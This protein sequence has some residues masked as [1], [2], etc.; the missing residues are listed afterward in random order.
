MLAAKRLPRRFFLTCGAGCLLASLALGRAAPPQQ[1]PGVAPPPLPVEQIIREFASKEAEFKQARDNYTYTQSVR[2][3]EFDAEGRRGGEFNRVSEIIFT[4]EGKRF[5]R[6]TREPPSTLR[7]VS[8][9]A[10]DLED[11]RNIQPFVLTNE[12]LPKYTLT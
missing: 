12:D 3:Q 4:P 6:I 1:G 11:I 2:V 9:S 5:E 10:E 8:L 7:M